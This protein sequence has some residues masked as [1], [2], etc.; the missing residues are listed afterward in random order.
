MI[1]KD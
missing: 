1:A